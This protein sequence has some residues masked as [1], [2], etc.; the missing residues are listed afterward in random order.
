[1]LAIMEA[2]GKLWGER[3]DYPHSDTIL[4]VT[5]VSERAHRGRRAKH[6]GTSCRL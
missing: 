5:Y 1:M 3:A 6:V 4:R 2:V